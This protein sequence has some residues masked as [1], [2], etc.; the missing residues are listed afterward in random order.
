M[1]AKSLCPESLT[2]FMVLQVRLG[3]RKCMKFTEYLR[4][5]L[6]VQ[7]FATRTTDLSRRDPHLRSVSAAGRRLRGS[8]S[9]LLCVLG[10]AYAVLSVVALQD[11]LSCVQY[12]H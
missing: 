12:I 10:V 6:S 4:S 8:E 11:S 9:D 3:C 7:P 2:S 1:T 5:R